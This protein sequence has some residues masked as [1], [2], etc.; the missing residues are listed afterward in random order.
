MVSSRNVHLALRYL[1]G[2][3]TL[4]YG[5]L[6]L[7][8]HERFSQLTNM[9]EDTVRQLALR[10]IASGVRIITASDP[11]PALRSRIFYDL[12]DALRLLRRKPV[13]AP[14]AV[15]WGLLAVAVLMTRNQ[16]AK[17]TVADVAA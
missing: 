4:A 16:E 7:A 8:R 17:R 12:G 6:S 15:A 3:G 1:L 10:D 11:A 9:N 13:L 2:G 5:V 14:V